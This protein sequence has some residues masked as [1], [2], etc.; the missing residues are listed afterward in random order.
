MLFGI[1]LR[2]SLTPKF[3][4]T[5][6]ITYG[7]FMVI[8]IVELWYLICGNNWYWLLNLNLIYL[9]DVMEWNRKWRV[10][11]N[12]AKIRLVLF[13]QSNNTGTIDVEMDGSVLEEK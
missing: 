1:Y 4:H 2:N 3:G 9:R 6:V 12:A 11:F 8:L 7:D 10:D 5:Y 13:D